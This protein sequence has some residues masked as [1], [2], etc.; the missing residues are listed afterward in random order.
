MLDL[1]SFP[2]VLSFLVLWL[3]TAE[4]CLVCGHCCFLFSSRSEVYKRLKEDPGNSES[5]LFTSQFPA[6]LAG[7]PH[8]LSLGVLL[9]LYMVFGCA[10]RGPSFWEASI[11]SL[12]YIKQPLKMPCAYLGTFYNAHKGNSKV[13][14][15]F[16]AWSAVMWVFYHN[17]SLGPIPDLKLTDSCLSDIWKA[18][19]Q[20][21]FFLILLR[22]RNGT[23]GLRNVG[24]AGLHLSP[25]LL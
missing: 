20:N 11:P 19:S 1:T 8:C 15:P 21:F 9:V 6:L 22:S 7:C 24:Q 25:P 13:S 17:P 18:T 16:C 5:H 12:Y 14:L 10:Y 4:A 2:L 3:G 23:T